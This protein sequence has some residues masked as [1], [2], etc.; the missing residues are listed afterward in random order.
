MWIEKEICTIVFF[1]F[2]SIKVPLNGSNLV[3]FLQI[4]LVN[5]ARGPRVEVS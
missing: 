5:R 1:K 2:W 4:E 3:R